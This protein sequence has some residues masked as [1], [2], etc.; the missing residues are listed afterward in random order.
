MIADNGALRPSLTRVLD[1]Y[2]GRNDLEVGRVDAR[3]ALSGVHS[4]L[5]FH[6][7]L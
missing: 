2:N 1:S 4:G 7:A 5:R 3:A 6:I